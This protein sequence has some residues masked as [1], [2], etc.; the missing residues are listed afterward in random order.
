[1]VLHAFRS[2]SAVLQG[3]GR[4]EAG[5]L[6]RAGVFENQR[7]PNSEEWDGLRHSTG[8]AFSLIEAVVRNAIFRTR[9][10]AGTSDGTLSLGK[11]VCIV[12]RGVE[13]FRDD[14][15]GSICVGLFPRLSERDP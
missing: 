1:M 8:P 13:E 10:P 7:Y 2:V 15:S 14:G 5:V 4:T 12:G 3:S 6:A 9:R 11:T